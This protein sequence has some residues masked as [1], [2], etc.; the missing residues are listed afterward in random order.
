M[1]TGPIPRKPNA[2]RP[3]ANTAGRHHDSSE[4]VRADAVS[5]AHQEQNRGSKPVGAHIAGH[6]SGKNI[7]RS[8]AFSRRGDDFSHM[9]DS[10]EVKTFTSRG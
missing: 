6:E 2:T 10:V 5:D 3:K 8:S 7:Q 4:T 1:V 9:R